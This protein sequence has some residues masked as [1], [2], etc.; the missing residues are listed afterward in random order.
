MSET[1]NLKN[2]GRIPDEGNGRTRF[3]QDGSRG[4][5]ARG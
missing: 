2:D 4:C 1:N 5:G 3:Q